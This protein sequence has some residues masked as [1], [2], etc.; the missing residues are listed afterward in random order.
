[1]T[2]SPARRLVGTARDTSIPISSWIGLTALVVVTVYSVI[3]RQIFTLLAEAIRRDLALS[4]TQ[5]GLLQ[6]VGL[7]LVS[8]LTTY[9]IAWLADR[10]D[11]RLVTSCCILVWS[12][13]VVVCAFAPNF[14]YLLIGASL[15]GVG[16]A[17]VVPAGYAMIADLFPESRRQLANSVLAI[18][19]TLSTSVGSAL[20]GAS[21]LAGD[22]FR[23]FLPHAL[24]GLAQ[25]RLGFLVTALFTPIAIILILT[26]PRRVSG[27]AKKAIAAS[28]EFSMEKAPDAPLWQYFRHD[29]P[30]KLNLFVAMA[31][32]TF[33]FGSVAT[34]IP[35]IAARDYHQTPQAAGA[36]MGSMALIAGA[37]GFVLSNLLMRWLRP[38]FGI[39]LPMM[40]LAAVSFLA[41]PCS[42]LIVFARNADQLYEFWGLQFVLLMARQMVGP[43]VLQ[44]MTPTHLRA[45]VF[46]LLGV[47]S[48]VA[49]ISSPLVVGLISDR[50]QAVPHGLLIAA[51]ST[52]TIALLISGVI[53]WRIV[54]GY[55][56]L[57][58]EANE[59]Q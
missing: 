13:A 23:P 36:W 58:V 26:L 25:W 12:L 47:S 44:N 39:R 54:D 17:G 33:G 56:E 55:A 10:F 38:R 19:V 27:L 7:A 4:D 43:T 9:P 29:M 53:L 15:V 59:A 2:S 24:S 40:V 34:W 16:E 52:S 28:S 30:T 32:S 46:A 31:V 1:M 41:A 8:L 14:T 21:V 50:L 35:V 37:V 22:K 57:T 48:A 3:D 45:R 49:G 42:I 51:T 5:L 6:G 20:A 18:G 11:R